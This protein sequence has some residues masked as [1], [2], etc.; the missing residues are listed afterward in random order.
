MAKFSTGELNSFQDTQESLLQDTCNI[1]TYA[2]TQN[3]YGEPTV[4]YTVASGIPCGLNMTNGIETYRGSVIKTET[5][6]VIRLP[7]NT[8]IS[9]LDKV[10]ITKR[11]GVTITGLMFEVSEQPRRGVSGIQIR[12]K[13]TEY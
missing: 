6:A 7:M 5:D 9:V 12:L 11:F 4:T 8:N 13:R 3:S 1:Y 2:S 10:E